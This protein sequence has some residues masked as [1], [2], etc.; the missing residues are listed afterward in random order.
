MLGFFAFAMIGAAI[1]GDVDWQFNVA[2]V[3]V[4]VFAIG[5]L[6]VLATFFT[7]EGRRWRRAA[8]AVGP[9]RMIDAMLVEKGRSRVGSVL[10]VTTDDAAYLLRTRN[11]WDMDTQQGDR[12]TLQLY[13]TGPKVSGAYRN[14]RGGRPVPV[15]VKPWPHPPE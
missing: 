13:G 5:L 4:L 9:D 10:Y 3:L 14:D 6:V 2:I 1:Q 12:I 15:S 11:T 7:R 8:A